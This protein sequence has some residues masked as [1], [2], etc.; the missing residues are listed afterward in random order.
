MNTMDRHD[1]LH[2]MVVSLEEKNRRLSQALTTARAQLLQMK[3]QVE[4]VNTP[5]LALATLLSVD[6]QDRQAEVVVSGRHMRVAIAPSVDSTTLMVGAQVRLDEKM[7][8][9]APDSY[10][11]AGSVA[12]V[13]EMLGA[14]RVL[15]GI[16]G[17]GEYVMRLSAQ[18]EGRLRPG[19]SVLV[20]TRASVVLERVVRS[21]VEQLL[22]PEVPNINWENI[23]GLETQIQQVRDT[24]ELPFKHP[25][26]YR[27][28]GLHPPK[29]ILL[30]GPP[31]SGKTLIAQAVANSLATS[32]GPR[33]YFLSIK[34]PELLNKYVGETERQIRALFA[35]ARALASSDVPVVIFF[36]EMEALFRTRGTGISSDVETLIV[37]QLLAEMDGVES[38]DNVVIIG[39]SNRADM[40]DP[41]VLRPGRL[42]VRVRVDRPDR[43]GAEDIFNKYLVPTLPLNIEEVREVGSASA[44]VKRMIQ[45][46]L[47]RLFSTD[48]STALFDATL[49]SGR[50]R[51]IRVADVISGALIAGT[52]ERAKKHAI[53]DQ[54]HHKSSGLKLEHVLAGVNEEIQESI[55]LAATSSPTDWART[56][57]LREDVVLVQPLK[58]MAQ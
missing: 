35:R 42:D 32:D 53:K 58:G 5:P 26:L 31:G 48:D 21:D 17:G 43:T 45:A 36:D 52:V 25:E 20:D 56:I 9:S 8:L 40:I 22:T 33:T 13:K 41:A 4:Q 37:P 49:A 18:V 47:D 1:D 6:H 50:V 39:A 24:I 19:D 15:V 10:Q 7:V 14:D 30:Y 11:R 2:R 57:G 29:G 38:L 55:E 51:R 27:S 23:G 44:L 46:A 12:S 28:F 16:D 54:L 3:E 34:G